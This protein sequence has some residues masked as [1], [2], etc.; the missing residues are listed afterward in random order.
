MWRSAPDV[1]DRT[2]VCAVS[3]GQAHD[4]H[5]GRGRTARGRGAALA[6][7]A[8]AQTPGRP[9]AADPG[10]GQR[11]ELHRRAGDAEPDHGRAGAAAPP[12][13][14][15][16]R[17]LE[18]PQRRLPDGLLPGLG[19]ARER[20]D[21]LD[22]L[23]PRVRLDRLRL[24]RADRHRLRRARPAGARGA[25]PGHP[26][27]ARGDAAAARGTSRAARTR[28]RTSPAAATSTSTT[29][30]APSSR[31]TTARC[32]RSRSARTASLTQTRAYDLS[33]GDRRRR[34][35]HLGAARLERAALVRHP[36]AASS[37]PSTATAE[38]VRSTE[39]RRGDLELVRRRRDRRRLH[40][41]RQ[42]PLPL[43]RRRRPGSPRS[44]GARP[45][46]TPG[47]A[48]PARA[49]PARGRPRR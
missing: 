44:A 27:D 34:R 37:G 20:H 19:P 48:S 40:R 28:S 13:H 26:G 42:G 17:P 2:K 5:R 14:G 22:L 18:H 47:S 7:A 6:A 46:R 23:R 12:V 1:M 4:P 16:E 32:S 15:A 31:P 29:A 36:R 8:S 30:T 21:G 35:D 41:L 33:G 45:I 24:P 10:L 49:T 25:R 43:R 11:P 39:A 3:C 9:A 38:R